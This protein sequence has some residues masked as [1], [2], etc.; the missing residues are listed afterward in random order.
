MADLSRI[1]R[2][3]S[4]DDARMRRYEDRIHATTARYKNFMTGLVTRSLDDLIVDDGRVRRSPD[5]ELVIQ[6]MQEAIERGLSGNE[7][8]GFSAELQGIIEVRARTLNTMMREMGLQEGIIQDPTGLRPV[9]RAIDDMH[10]NLADGSDW[11]REEFRSLITRYRGDIQQGVPVTRSELSRA[12]V[13]KGGVLP[14]YADV[15][16]VLQLSAVDREV[17]VMQAERA[18]VHKM[19]YLG[20][21][22]RA[23]RPWCEKHVN[24]VEPMEYWENEENDAG[25]NPPLIYGGGWN[26]RHRLIP[27]RDEW[28]D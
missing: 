28:D 25:P 5:N 7:W 20:P 1:M 6:R 11:T 4:R 23:T 8:D 12:F 10:S 18:G 9:I 2:A 14:Q 16:A 3:V 27:W 24:R 19:K 17:K 22:D 21:D 13:S 15:T 26:C